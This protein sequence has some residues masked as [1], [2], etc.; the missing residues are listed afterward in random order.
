MRSYSKKLGRKPS[1]GRSRGE[2]RHLVVRPRPGVPTQGLL[3]AGQ[4]VLP[5]ALGRGGITAD[6]REGDGGTPLGR[7]RLLAGYFRGDHVAPGRSALSLV[8]I[9]ADLGWCEVPD[10]RNYNRPVRLPYPVSHETMRRRD[11]LYDVCIVLDWNITPRRRGRG[12]AI[13]FHLARP[14]Y[15][16]TEGCVAISR[17]DMLRLLPFLSPRSVLTVR[18]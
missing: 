8:P 18:R 9:R 3:R 4:A 10:D 7:M 13:F 11:R 12:S 15:T 16:P 6:K 17:A 5:C 1:N 14:G 2:L